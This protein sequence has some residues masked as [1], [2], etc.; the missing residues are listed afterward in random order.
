M[1]LRDFTCTRD[2]Y[3]W[4]REH[5]LDRGHLSA[6]Q[7]AY[8]ENE[9]VWLCARCED[10]GCR[11]GR[12]LAHMAEDGI[13]DAQESRGLGDVYKRQVFDG[14]RLVVNV[15]R[16]RKVMLTCNVAYLFGLA[17]GT[18]GKLVGVVYGAAGVGS[19][20][21]ALII[22]VPEYC[23]PAFYQDEPAWVPVLPMFSRKEGTR[24]TREQFPV[25][26]GF[27]ITVKKGRRA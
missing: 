7:K 12:K 5:D 2:D 6:E 3:D 21:E 26:A 24:M 19:F 10:V 16:G 17:N 22:D 11:N 25:A 8:F 9:A 23:R 27:A 14:L 15:V 1:R 13:R 4:W 20:P 18:R